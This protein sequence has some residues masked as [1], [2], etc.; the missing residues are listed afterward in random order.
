MPNYPYPYSAYVA[1]VLDAEGFS[2]ELLTMLQREP[3]LAATAI[4]TLLILH[5]QHQLPKTTFTDLRRHVE[6]IA[7]KQAFNDKLDE[8]DE[9]DKTRLEPAKE[10][11]DVPFNSNNNE[12]HDENP[13]QLR[14]SS[15][16]R[17]PSTTNEA[18]QL[19]SGSEN[20]N[21]TLLRSP[22]TH[23]EQTSINSNGTPQDPIPEKKGTHQITGYEIENL[24][25]TKTGQ[26]GRQ[27]PT[28]DS[29]KNKLNKIDQGVKNQTTADY[30]ETPSKLNVRNVVSIFALAAAMFVI[31][32]VSPGDVETVG[33]APPIGS[34]LPTESKIAENDEIRLDQQ[35]EQPKD[36]PEISSEDS[37]AERLQ[38]FSMRTKE[39]SNKS[40]DNL[41][42]PHTNLTPD[43]NS[44]TTDDTTTYAATTYPKSKSTLSITQLYQRALERATA[45]RLEPSSDPDSATGYLKLMIEKDK[46]NPLIRQTR[47][48][49][50][51]AYL[52]LAK[53]A[54]QA[55]NWDRVD[56][57][58]EKAITVR[59]EN[60]IIN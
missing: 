22:D 3:S 52:A 39:L 4:D 40:V 8:Q 36:I 17:H 6:T 29:N 50:A 34:T 7:A 42:A 18:T 60:S 51:R 9:S 33:S 43:I 11:I 28:T 24:S 44:S 31:Y 1:G 26:R 53:Q 57:L 47:S 5:R 59:M 56:Q 23:I 13:T 27:N 49:I 37:L 16:I 32:V 46:D 12:S 45:L 2:A 48:E 25:N 54:R 10:T 14:N 38:K 21:A 15:A 55:G 30:D 58:L 19:R 41:A 35:A 20:P